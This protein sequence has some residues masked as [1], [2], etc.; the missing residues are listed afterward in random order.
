VSLW[1][2]EPVRPAFAVDWARPHAQEFGRVVRK[3]GAVVILADTHSIAPWMVACEEAG[4]IWMADM[5]ILWNSGKPRALNF[6]SLSTHILWFAVPG[7]R[8]TWNSKSRLIPSNILVCSKLHPAR[9]FLPTQKPV[10]ITNFLISLLTRKG[11]GVL[12]PFCGSGS[13]LVSCQAVG[14]D[15]LGIDADKHCC[16]IATRRAR[17]WELEEEG[18]L[19]LWANGK[20]EEIGK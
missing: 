5:T 13:T 9:R 18:D 8:H 10:E 11:D 15:W 4:L 16:A 12:D 20:L 14:R 7:A 19:H 6:G 1:E 17:M 3:G 2:E